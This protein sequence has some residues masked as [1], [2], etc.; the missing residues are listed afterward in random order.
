MKLLLTAVLLCASVAQAQESPLA[1]GGISAL[2]SDKAKEAKIATMLDLSGK[3]GGAAYL[4]IWTLKAAGEAGSEYVSLGAGGMIREGGDK[5][6]L[7]ALA[8]NLPAIS[9]KIWDFQ[10]AKDHVKRAKFPPIWVGPYVLVP[11]NKQYVIGSNAGVMVS[12]GL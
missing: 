1:I 6:P 12:V 11:T 9:G 10:W 8:F 7:V 2:I 3:F 5:S 4:P